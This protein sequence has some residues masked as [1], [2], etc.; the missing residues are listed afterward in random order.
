MPWVAASPTRD[1]WGVTS[2]QVD[3]EWVTL[4]AAAVPLRVAIVGGSGRLGS[5]LAT[6]L[7]ETGHRVRVLDSVVPA[8]KRGVEFVQTALA[9]GTSLEGRLDGID[10][11]IHLAALHGAHL[12]GGHSRQDFWQV[13]VG[14]TSRLL[15]ECERA[16]VARV[17]AASSTSVYGAG[18][19]AGA[20]R[21]L[22]EETPLAPED[23]YDFTKIATERLLDEVRLRTPIVATALRFGRFFYPSEHDYQLRKLSTGLDVLD[24]CQAV[25]R[26]MLADTVP[27]PAYCVASDL[28]LSRGQRER[29][30][31][32]L[33][34]VLEEA[35]PGL[36]GRCAERGIPLP[37]RVGKS[38]DTSAI[39]ADLGYEPCRTIAWSLLAAER[40]TLDRRAPV[41]AP[42]TRAC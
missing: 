15:R 8:P 38:V 40:A 41:A 5:W 11:V 33:P 29:L 6:V 28:S 22:D 35:L 24:A 13:N 20:A 26:V 1:V 25:V 17:V 7:A 16:G 3:L 32:D 31:T 9:R 36:V 37:E 42:V 2:A 19:P 4:L 14:G 18:S 23:I 21:V 27:R 30:G 39:R 12:A 10:C 34:G